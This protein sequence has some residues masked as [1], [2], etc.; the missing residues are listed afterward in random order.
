MDSF[1]LTNDDVTLKHW[2][3]VEYLTDD[4]ERAGYFEACLDNCQDM[5]ADVAR[6]VVLSAL[7]GIARSRGQTLP[8]GIDAA[9]L[10]GFFAALK[11]LRLRLRVEAINNN[12]IEESDAS[13]EAADEEKAAAAL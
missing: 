11:F 3:V 9:T 5:P 7:T 13:T 10:E 6:K 2:D 8:Q 4:A 12:V 1:K